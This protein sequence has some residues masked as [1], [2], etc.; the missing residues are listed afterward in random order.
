MAPRLEQAKAERE[1]G[2]GSFVVQAATGARPGQ[3]LESRGWAILAFLGA[4]G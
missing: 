2:S 4:Q 3:P 1:S